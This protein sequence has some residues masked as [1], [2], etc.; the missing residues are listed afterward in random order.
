MPRGRGGF[1]KAS[2]LRIG[3]RGGHVEGEQEEGGGATLTQYD[4]MMQ[5]LI[6]QDRNDPTPSLPSFL[7]V[8]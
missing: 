1:K 2:D 5:Q 7:Q 3:V 6:A 4:V 8:A